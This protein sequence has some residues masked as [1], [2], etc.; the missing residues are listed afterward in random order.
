MFLASIDFDILRRAICSI[1][2]FRCDIWFHTLLLLA[3]L[4]VFALSPVDP[5]VLDRNSD[6]DNNH[7]AR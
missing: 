5:F 3:N 4:H 2:R 7:E 6:D 1:S